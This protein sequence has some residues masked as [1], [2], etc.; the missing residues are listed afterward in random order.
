[1]NLGGCLADDMGL[2][3]TIQTLCLLQ[4]LKEN[5]GGTSLLVVPTSLV[6]NWQQEAAKFTPEISIYVHV[7]NSRTQNASDFGQTDL[8]LTS[9]AILRRDKHL[10]TNQHF[11]YIVLDEAQSIKNPQSDITQVCLSLSAK[12]HLTLTGTPI[13]NS[14]TDLWSQVHFFNR[15]M[16]G[17][18]NHFMRSCKQPEKHALYRQL[19]RPF[20]LR[21]HKNAVLTDLPEKTIIVQPCEMSD[22]QQRF[23]RD[24]RN[25][26]R[27]KFLESKDENNKI[28][29][30]VL[31]EGLLRLRQSANHPKLV[32]SVYPG[33]SGKFEIVTQLL[34]DVVQ[35]GDKVLIFSSFVEHLKLY[36]N[37]LDEREIQYCYLDG[38]TKDR[39]EQVEKFQQDDA[40]QVFLLSLKAGGVGL[41]L[42]RASYVFLLDPWW[43]P[44]AEAQA[45]DRA[46][47]IGQ[48]NN[49]F[50]Y[51]FITQN[52]IEEK[53][54]KLQE[55]KILLSE[56]MLE[57]DSTEILKK[58]DIDEV[59]KL[60]N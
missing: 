11:N 49:V 47:R 53:I 10:F 44:A 34:E 32:D 45:Y 1:M 55:Q 20:L 56:T 33:N 39:K 28:S 13:E 25:S 2:G 24:I 21:R 54:L 5:N 38:S 9:Y 18:A 4:W 23:Y 52:S 36:R 29:P 51:K 35:Q 7:G 12:Q 58:L 46:H 8:L 15:N 60:I 48:K 19:I 31:L 17:S 3:K 26:Y 22:E 14:L 41:N 30:I 43:N 42:T 59:M 27:E 50:V 57:N 37:Y 40:S 6:Y 16:L